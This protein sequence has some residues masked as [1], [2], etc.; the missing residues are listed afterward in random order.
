MYIIFCILYFVYYYTNIKKI[1]I[2]KKNLLNGGG[3]GKAK[4]VKKIVLHT[5]DAVKTIA[6]DEKTHL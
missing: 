6:E 5:A 1:L 3:R 4:V 2:R